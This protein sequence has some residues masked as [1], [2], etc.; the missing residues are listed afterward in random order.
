MT[1]ISHNLF[2][3]NGYTSARSGARH[4]H[5][6][7][8]TSAQS[9]QI[10]TQHHPPPCLLECI[11]VVR[12]PPTIPPFRTRPCWC[13]SVVV[14][15]IV[16]DYN[17]PVASRCSYGISTRMPGPGIE[18]WK[19]TETLDEQTQFQHRGCWYRWLKTKFP[20]RTTVQHDDVWTIQRLDRQSKWI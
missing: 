14:V 13:E 6:C 20:D 17:F 11:P 12:R 4:W 1:N 7:H 10:N 8:G 9:Q 2:E 19:T 3:T 15:V 18:P 16:V 5:T